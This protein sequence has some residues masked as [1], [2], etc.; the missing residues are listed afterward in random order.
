M[1]IYSLVLK[2]I[3]VIDIWLHCNKKEECIK[4]ISWAH[5]THSRDTRVMNYI[6]IHL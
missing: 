3:Q 4:K 5:K 1:F 2:K 6:N